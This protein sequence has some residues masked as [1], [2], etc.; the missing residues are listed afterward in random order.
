[1][2]TIYFIRHSKPI[3]VNNE[4]NDESLQEKNEKRILSIEGE[5]IAFNWFNHDEFDNIKEVFSSNYVRAI[6]TAKYLADKNNTKVVVV[7]EFG[8]RKIGIKSWDQYTS[9]FEI[10]Q[11]NDN[12][13][14]LKNGESLNEVREREFK[15][16]INILNSSKSNRIAI[17]FHSTAMMTLLKTWC[18]VSYDSDYYFKGNKFFD[19]KWNYCETFKLKFDDDNN[20]ISIKNLR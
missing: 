12:N 3:D 8:E 9:D 4:F 5:Q 20:L 10:H 11:F 13:Y 2:K 14:K 17:V 1:M 19:G 16:L 6:G 18:E 15:A 7:P